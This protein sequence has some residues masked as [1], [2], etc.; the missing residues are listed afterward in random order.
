MSASDGLTVLGVTA[1][2]SGPTGTYK[3]TSLQASGAWN[4]G[5]PTGAFSWNYPI[6]APGVP[7]GLQP[8]VALGYSSQAVDGKTGASNSQSSWIGDGWNYEPGFIERRYKACNND[9]T[10]ATNTTKVGD[11]CWYND[12]ATLSLGGKSTELVYDTTK[13]WHPASDSGE[14]IE[15]LT[16]TVN[17]DNNNEYWK[18]TTNNGTQYFFGRHQLPGWSD[19]GHGAEDDPVTN[20]TWTVPVFGNHSGEP[21]Y[22]A[23]FA[24]ASCQ[25]AW[26]WQLDY[27]VDPRG[28]AMAYYWSKETNNYGLNVSET[29]GKATVTQYTRGGYLSR[30]EYGLRSSSVFS[31]KAMAQIE[32][33]AEKRCLTNCNVFDEAN[34]KNWPDVPFD[35]YCKDGSTE[36]KY[37]YSPSFWSRML[38][39]GIKTKVLTGGAYKDVDSWKLEQNFPPAGDGVSTPMWL[40]SITR[41]GWSGGMAELTPVRFEGVQKDNRVDKQGDGLAPFVRLRMSQIVTETGGVIG[42]DYLDPGCTVTSLPPADGTNTTRCYPVKWAFEG[43]TAKLDW[44][45]SYPVRRVIEGDN[46]AATPDTVTEYTYVGDAAW[47][48]STDEF[49]KP[50]DRTHSIARGYHLVQTRKGT[51]SD[52]RTLSEARYFRGIDGAA[53]K[54]SAGAAVTDREQFAGMPREQ[55]TYNGDGGPLVS[56]TS[57]TPWRSAASA[58]R[59]RTGLPNLEAYYTGNQAEETRTTTS[60]GTRTTKVTRAF[61]AYGMVTQVSGHG[62]TAK[63]GDESCTTTDYARN[64]N[65]DVWILNTVSRVETVAVTC[66]STPVRPRDVT[67]DVRT[68][69]D[70]GALG[71]APTKGLV[72][73]TDRIRGSGTGYDPTMTVPRTCGT[74]ANQIC[75]DDYGRALKVTDAYGKET[76]TTYTPA[77]GE[78]PTLTVSTNPLG[79]ST[80]TVTDPLRGQPTKVTDA[81]KKVT[82][83][84]YDALGRITNVWTPT[85]SATT[86]PNAANYVFE[87][88]VRN[89]GPTVVTTKVLDHNSDYQT[90]YA[91]YDGL[92]RQVQTQDVSPSRVGRLMSETLFNSRGESWLSSGTYYATGSPEPVLATG[93]QTAYPAATETRYDGAGRPVTVIAKK[94]G[95]ETKRTT[96]A[97]TGDTTTVTPPQ[98]G[99]TTTTLVDALGRTTEVQEHT[100]PPPSPRQSVKYGYDKHGRQ[101]QMVDQ[102]GVTWTYGYDT[103][104]RKVSV[105]DPDKGKSTTTYDQGDRAVSATDA[106]GVTL[107]TSYDAIGRK[108]ALKK[109]A[110]T[111]SAWTY[112]TVAKGQPTASTRYV[113]GKAY[114]SEV[115]AYSALY[116][117]SATKVTIPG[118]NGEPADTYTWFQSFTPNTHLPTFTRHPAV[119]DLPAETVATAYNASGLVS[120]VHAGGAPLIASTTYDHY[121]RA[122]RLTYGEFSRQLFITNEFDEHTGN[123]TKT[124][125]DR[126]AAPQ[127]VEDTQYT[128]DPA[129][130]VKQIASAYGQGATRTTDTQCFTVDALRRITEAWTNSGSA[131]ASEPSNTVVGG[132][133]PYWTSYTYDAVGNRK[134]ETQH[135]TSGGPTNDAVR[136]YAAPDAGKHNLPRVTHSATGPDA[137]DENYTYDVAGNMVTRKAG[138]AE[139]QSL[140]WDDE[141]HLKS[142]TQGGKTSSYAYDTEGARFIRKDSTGTTLYLPGG[143]E[144]HTDNAGLRKGTRYYDVGGKNVAM[145]TGGQLT[146]VLTD[147]HNTASTQI[148]ADATQN[149]TRRKTTIFGAPRGTQPANWLGDKGFVG[150][151][152][153][154]DTG[155]THLGA[156]EYDPLIGR[157]ISVDP[158]LQTNVPQTLNG[159]S[160]G[161][162]N[163]LINPDPS[164]LGVPE[165]HTGVITGCSNGVP[166]D[167]YVYHPDRENAN[168]CVRSCYVDA[169]NSYV[170]PKKQEK[171]K[172]KNWLGRFADTAKQQVQNHIISPVQQLGGIYSDGFNCITMDG[173]CGDFVDG[174]VEV[175]P[176]MSAVTVVT[177]L[178]AGAKEIYGDFR[179][180]RSAEGSAKLVVAAVA[181]IVSKKVVAKPKGSKCS[182]FVAGSLVLMSDG[183]TKPIE[184]LEAGDKV[185]ATDPETGRTFVKEVTATR[186]S[187]GMKNLVKIAMTEAPTASDEKQQSTLTAT[188]THPFWVPDLAR[189]VDAAEL[190]PGQWLRTSSGT[191]VQVTAIQRWIAPE[192]VHNLTVADLHTYYVLAGVT[193]VLV[194]NCGDGT[195]SNSKPDDL[196]FE[197]MAADFEGV[198]AMPAGSPGFAQAVA[199]GGRYLWTV[200]GRGDLNIVRDA[201]GIHHT[202]ASG[203]SPV[204]G[205]GQIA[206][207]K[208]GRVTSFDNMT[209]HYTPPCAQCAASF[210]TNGVDAFGLAGVRVPR[211]AIRDYGGKA[212]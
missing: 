48:K 110:T 99:T 161:A 183:K 159:Y 198:S 209:G 92:L 191:H 2:D 145:R 204:V 133:D 124:Y 119:S 211:A 166:D 137:R 175:Q 21:C 67:D 147:R 103:R 15:K 78:A 105:D 129:G 36:C 22:N 148:T 86:Y 69:Y 45:H 93:N 57:H 195:V 178:G 196:P 152:I 43:D 26:R 58:T 27:V 72:T 17:G 135:K 12:N 33:T 56:A 42:I 28:N 120:T 75:F 130:N 38:L 151:T 186:S 210:I 102:S 158:L 126:D 62:D 156:R 180:G 205:A 80:E 10:G 116:K 123:L 8:S 37:Q 34:A 192:R 115:T 95:D 136:T 47:S 160:Y 143:T 170:P 64:T 153:D 174:L 149:V 98:G 111:L 212:P 208:G 144:L 141:G 106:R 107:A 113:D 169:V 9:K 19:N 200:G 150:G 85:R 122:S 100:G 11:L 172:K 179:A 207:G 59:A 53:V 4:V 171:K 61:D 114:V 157:F 5:G 184:A 3:A 139:A 189:W 66:D 44:F 118:E 13:G 188:G 81:N 206:I 6:A 131:C 125:T 104:G 187:E 182:S 54:N 127:R 51:G 112:D 155:L 63:A 162:Q 201:P 173:T 154:A 84:T 167:H 65:P 41:T 97:Y 74:A 70:G 7:G 121:G 194:H 16:D 82:T 83:T 168:A 96:T 202:I 49:T 79:H 71:A 88:A 24:K 14:K 87:Y 68:S 89:T 134:T 77:A 164:G 20:S 91:F 46:L 40:S 197:Q 31:K 32:F 142:V 146:F 23:S 73:A 76:S 108:I 185:L 163:P 199:D 165:C 18:V 190:Q 128:Y 101:D 90:S 138:A 193:P 132:E 109:G 35:Q 52:A 176:I 55:A 29:T 117:P 94:Y 203:G 177:G 1:G 30:I 50:E 60:G 140:I 181:A 39:K 25:Q